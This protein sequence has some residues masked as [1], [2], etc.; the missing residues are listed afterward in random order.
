MKI[1]ILLLCFSLFAASS[2]QHLQLQDDPVDDFLKQILDLIK[3]L[4]PD[5]IPELGIPPLDPF[6]VPPFDDIHVK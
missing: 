6:E 4:M 1:V 2:G 5:G 3:Q